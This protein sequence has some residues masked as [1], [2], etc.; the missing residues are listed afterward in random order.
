MRE[1]KIYFVTMRQPRQD[2]GQQIGSRIMI[3]RGYAWNMMISRDHDVPVDPK[4]NRNTVFLQNNHQK[5]TQEPPKAPISTEITKIEHSYPNINRG[6]TMFRMG[7]QKNETSGK[8][9]LQIL[10]VLFSFKQ[11]QRTVY[12]KLKA[13]STICC[14]KNLEKTAPFKKNEGQISNFQMNRS[15]SSVNRF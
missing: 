7:P 11:P 3:S 14:L 1:Q 13:K 2:G 8:H 4:K 10:T 15:P 12:S 6:I 9:F 5:L